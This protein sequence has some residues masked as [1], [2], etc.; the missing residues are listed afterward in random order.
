MS[1]A[2]KSNLYHQ[3]CWLGPPEISLGQRAALGLISRWD[4]DGEVFNGGDYEN[5]R[6][7]FVNLT[8]ESRAEVSFPRTSAL[9]FSSISIFRIDSKELGAGVWAPR[10]EATQS[11]RL[12]SDIEPLHVVESEHLL[13]EVLREQ[14]E[15]ELPGTPSL[16]L[17]RDEVQ[18]LAVQYFGWDILP[19][20][21]ALSRVDVAPG[22][23]SESTLR[24]VFSCFARDLRFLAVFDSVDLSIQVEGTE[25]FAQEVGSVTERLGFKV[26][27]KVFQLQREIEETFEEAI[28]NPRAERILRSEEGSDCAIVMQQD[29]TNF[30]WEVDYK[31]PSNRELHF[32]M[33]ALDMNEA[34]A[35]H[36]AEQHAKFLDLQVVTSEFSILFEASTRDTT[37]GARLLEIT[38][39]FFASLKWAD[40]VVFTFRDG[41]E[42]RYRSIEEFEANPPPALVVRAA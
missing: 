3:S 29:G 35:L 34:E 21:F 18:E 26:R 12:W 24:W 6:L 41:S 1:T 38:R 25:E 19:S 10:F 40:W 30:S 37:L 36:A 39:L 16:S 27:A 14:S 11:F 17:R 2:I 5:L 42:Y 15:D 20:N 9:T 22:V 13:D 32:A 4:S 8:D 7:V 23:Y 33:K 31:R 28:Y